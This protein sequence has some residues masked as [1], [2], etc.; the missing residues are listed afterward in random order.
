MTQQVKNLPA[1]QET[2]VQFLVQ[3][4][5]L[6]EEMETLSVFLPEKFRGQ[7]NLAG[8]SP[9]GDKESTGLSNFLNGINV[10]TK[11]ENVT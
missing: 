5:P 3:E 11:E 9:R 7:R 6:E 4:L 2:R 8:S 10:T 1:V